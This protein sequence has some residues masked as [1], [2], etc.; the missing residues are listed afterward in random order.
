MFQH[1]A[2][3]VCEQAGITAKWINEH[4]VAVWAYKHKTT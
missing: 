2:D 4:T 1:I 3:N